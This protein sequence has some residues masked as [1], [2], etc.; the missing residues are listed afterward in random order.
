MLSFWTLLYSSMYLV[1]CDYYTLTL[2]LS[3]KNGKIKNKS[4]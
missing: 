4:K 1:I 3:S 2:I